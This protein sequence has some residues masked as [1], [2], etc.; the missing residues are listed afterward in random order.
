[1]VKK[2]I[3]LSLTLVTIVNSKELKYRV[4]NKLDFTIEGKIIS[5]NKSR[6]EFEV[7]FE[8][9]PKKDKLISIP[10]D[11]WSYIKNVN[12]YVT[13]KELKEPMK[14]IISKFG[15]ESHRNAN[16]FIEYVPTVN[17]AKMEE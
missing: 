2:I 8:I 5:A 9:E 11:K 4:F 13:A 6:E 15:H 12:L 14:E 17:Y 16:V 7:K 3:L 10:E 1:M